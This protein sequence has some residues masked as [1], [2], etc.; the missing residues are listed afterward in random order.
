MPMTIPTPPVRMKA[1]EL[2][3]LATRK[4][5]MVQAMASLTRM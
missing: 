5:A 2:A 1:P 4:A 3:R